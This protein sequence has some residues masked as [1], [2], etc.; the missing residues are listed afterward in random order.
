[1]VFKCGRQGR[2]C[3]STWM[4]TEMAVSQLQSS[5]FF[6]SRQ[7]RMLLE[8]LKNSNKTAF[9]SINELDYVQ[10]KSS[11]PE[12]LSKLFSANYEYIFVIGSPLTPTTN[13]VVPLI[14]RFYEKINVPNGFCLK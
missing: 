6:R 10:F 5:R 12:I 2:L 3:I 9:S 8:L 1:M 14:F 13:T 11:Q 4:R 7:I